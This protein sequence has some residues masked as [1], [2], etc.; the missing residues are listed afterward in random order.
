MN[1][2]LKLVLICTIPKNVKDFNLS[3]IIK[4]ENT[5]PLT[6]KYSLIIKEIDEGKIKSDKKNTIYLSNFKNREKIE[7]IAGNLIIGEC[8]GNK[9][10]FSFIDSQF[11]GEGLDRLTDFSMN[12]KNPKILAFC[13]LDIANNKIDCFI[14]GTDECPLYI[15]TYLETGENNPSTDSIK[16]AIIIY[17]NFNN[18]RVEF[19]NYYISIMDYQSSTCINEKYI[20]N[21]AAM[22]KS[23]N[24]P[25][26][27]EFTL[28]LMN[29]DK[30]M[31]NAKCIF[32]K[33]TA[34]DSYNDIHCIIDDIIVGNLILIFDKIYIKEKE[35]YIVNLDGKTSFEFENV[36]CPLFSPNITGEILLP[37]NS[38]F[39]NSFYFILSL[40]T[41]FT[42]K[43][44]NIMYHNKTYKNNNILEFN[45]IPDST[46]SDEFLL[47]FDNILKE[48]EKYTAECEVPNIAEK[49]LFL[50]CSV[51]E[52]NDNKS[53][54]FVLEDTRD[55]IKVENTE[56]E[57]KGI[58]GLKIKNI[59]KSN[60]TE[61]EPDTGEPDTGEPDT[62][63]PD[64]G[65][66]D[67]GEQ[68]PDTTDPNDESNKKKE[69]GI[70]T[71]GKVILII[72]IILGVI[73]IVL[74]LLYFFYCKN[75]EEDI[76]SNATSNNGTSS[77]VDNNVD[78]K[79]NSLIN[80]QYIEK[81]IDDFSEGENKGNIK[82]DEEGYNYK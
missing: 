70:S 13:S 64:T 20:F 27:E 41:S 67:T 58:A 37:E 39:S 62:G 2:Y 35:I 26:N 25:E 14:N 79:Q 61:P 28:N 36:K 68:E 59:F 18:K 77:Q 52:V 34:I 73:L 78:E 74:V 56:I 21:L 43:I 17:S 53:D 65:E 32:S 69:G 19:T 46:T 63:E 60:K 11:E 23:G 10:K 55:I 81:K 48:E 31:I 6:D 75:K 1:Y 9:L 33:N 22:I 71:A 80:N 5:C 42:G 45:L 38:S 24:I 4:G 66:P 57:L 7:I 49:S 3:C 12:L 51:N 47:S 40:K 8:E 16:N 15:S 82:N 30:T 44:I 29:S 72:M 54:Y 76:S 50:N